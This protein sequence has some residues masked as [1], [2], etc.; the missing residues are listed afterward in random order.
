VN[1][2]D[3]EKSAEAKESKI[4]E[5]ILKLTRELALEHKS[6][7]MNRVGEELEA[8]RE[9]ESER[10]FALLNRKCLKKADALLDNLEKTLIQRE[11]LQKKADYNKDE[12]AK[13][14]DVIEETSAEIYTLTLF[15]GFGS[16]KIGPIFQMQDLKK[17][18]ELV[19][20]LLDEFASQLLLGAQ[21]NQ[22]DMNPFDYIYRSLGTK[23]QVLDEASEESQ[24]ILEYIHNTSEKKRPRNH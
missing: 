4:P 22:A 1:F 19:R 12:H 15:G 13:L 23:I 11:A 24:L 21:F 10:P 20:S 2:A 9:M 17:K 16:E 7:Q 5:T 6:K 18:K 14:V 8:E 3:L